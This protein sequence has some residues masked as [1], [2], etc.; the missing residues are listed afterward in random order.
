M[1]I[2]ILIGRI[3]F[4]AVFISGAVGHLKSPDAMAAYAE[5]KGIKPGKLA[6]YA[7]AVWMLVG[8]L[9]VLLGAWA[10]LGALMLA[11]FVLPTAFLMHG[12]W[13][14]TDAATKANEMLHFHKDLS[15]GGA[16]LALFGLFAAHGACVG[17]QLTKPLFDVMGH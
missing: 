16:A 7:S 14:E 2:A 11:V 13:K 4:V 12:F 17:L 5:A 8:S 10:D 15:L 9:L 1:D 3:L 6:V